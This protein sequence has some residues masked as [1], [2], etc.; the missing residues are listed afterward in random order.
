MNIHIAAMLKTTKIVQRSAM[1]LLRVSMTIR[2]LTALVSRLAMAVLCQDT[3]GALVDIVTGY[4]PNVL[5]YL[6]F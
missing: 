5:V 2:Q 1:L 6:C 3:H 4:K